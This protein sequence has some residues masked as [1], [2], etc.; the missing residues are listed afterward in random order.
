MM[1]MAIGSIATVVVVIGRGGVFFRDGLFMVA[2]C[3][4]YLEI[5]CLPFALIFDLN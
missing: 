5:E 2:S 3:H 1:M 4:I